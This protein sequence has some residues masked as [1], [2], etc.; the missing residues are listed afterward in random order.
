M[1]SGLSGSFHPLHQFSMDAKYV[2]RT[3]GEFKTIIANPGPFA[4]KYSNEYLEWY[5]T[6]YKNKVRNHER[7]E[8]QDIDLREAENGVLIKK[9]HLYTM[10]ATSARRR[11]FT[12]IKEDAQK[13]IDFYS[14]R[15]AAL[16]LWERRPQY[17][18]V[19]VI[20]KCST[21]HLHA[22]LRKFVDFEADIRVFW[23][24][25][26]LY[27]TLIME[28]FPQKYVKETPELEKIIE[29][30]RWE[31]TEKC[32]N[33]PSETLYAVFLRA[34]KKFN[35]QNAVECSVFLKCLE[36]NAVQT[37]TTFDNSVKINPNELSID[38]LLQ[39]APSGESTLFAAENVPLV[40]LYLYAEMNAFFPTN[41]FKLHP[42]A[43]EI[44]TLPESD[45]SKIPSPESLKF[46]FATSVPQI[47][48]LESRLREMQMMHRSI[49]KQDDRYINARAVYN[50]KTFRAEIRDAMT[51]RMERALK[52]FENATANLKPK[53]PEEEAQELAEK[54]GVQ[55][56]PSVYFFVRR[57][58]SEL[59]VSLALALDTSGT[60]RK[61]L[62]DAAKEMYLERLHF[63]D[64]KLRYI[65]NQQSKIA[66][67]MLD[68]AIQKAI[69]EQRDALENRKVPGY[70][71]FLHISSR[72]VPLADRQL[73]EYG[74]Q[75]KHSRQN[76]ARRYL[77]PFDAS[78]SAEVAE[79]DAEE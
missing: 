30:V 19:D 58:K 61:Y 63:F 25:V 16:D 39:Y 33:T 34:L 36:K 53:S 51:I 65:H 15:H 52:R 71:S 43:K 24:K 72:H 77:S 68:Q 41:V 22:L 5:W 2:A 1:S 56:K 10:P 27:C 44:V 4:V 60:V 7:R 40:Q 48:R 78:K 23:L 74:A 47:R 67:T 12:R 45:L 54:G 66:L 9:M 70:A 38:S 50:P 64:D 8:Q 37:L 3:F 59:S 32:S 18:F 31:R 42:A 17:P 76:Y 62:F 57:L 46:F 20:N 29:R 26:T 69:S 75:T 28:R 14:C 13:E 55:I 49:S 79:G 35:L 6:A 11:Y 73:D 21:F